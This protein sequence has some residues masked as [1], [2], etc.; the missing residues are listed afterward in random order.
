MADSGPPKVPDLITVP[1]QAVREWVQ[2][3]Q[4]QTVDVQLSRGTVDNLFL[5]LRR[6]AESQAKFHEC[7]IRYSQGDV[8][9]ANSLLTESQVSLAESENQLSLFMTNIMLSATR[10][11]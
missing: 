3:P 8:S 7:L 9:G 4:H 1:T 2:I 6:M 11:G 10:G 5:A